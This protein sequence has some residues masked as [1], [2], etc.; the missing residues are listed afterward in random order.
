[1]TTRPAR[2][3]LRDFWHD[4]PREGKLLLSVVAFQFIGTGLVLPFWV[5]YLHEIRG[6]SLDTTGLLLALLPAAGFL[7]V[8]PG[9]A[10]IDRIGPRK[11]MVA[12]LVMA[13]LGEVTMAFAETVPVAVVGLSLVGASFGLAWPSSQS[14]VASIVPTGIR[15]RYFGM[16]FALLNLGIGI[17]GVVGG[18]VAN[19]DRP[20]TFQ[21]MYLVEACSYVPALV[22]LLGPLRH[23][24]GPPQHQSHDEGA[25]AVG[26]LEVIKRPGVAAITVLSFASAFVGYAQLNAGLPA[27]ARA[28]SQVSTRGLGWAFAANTLVI[29]LLQLLV[30]QRIE[31]RRRTRVVVVMSVLWGVSW[32]LLSATSLIP[33]TLGATLLVAACASVF[34]LG[35]TLLQP[36]IP[37]MVNDMAPDHLRGRYNAV[38]SAGFQAASITGPPVAG[39]LIGHGLGSVYIGLLMAGLVLVVVVSVRLVEPRLSPLA[40]GLRPTSATPTPPQ[41][42]VAAPPPAPPVLADDRDW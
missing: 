33:G 41:G 4:L 30:L 8:A 32:L 16:N 14:M 37:A 38:S 21:V 1:M 35:E 26:Y 7:I 25:Q 24:G 15:Q 12:S 40:N 17:G 5:V 2:P 9:G 19:V 31:G 29:V 23:A 27:Y 28:I 6:F 13:S 36:T 42:S 34:A 11:T 22:L 10:L 18:L 20:V 39:F 3:P